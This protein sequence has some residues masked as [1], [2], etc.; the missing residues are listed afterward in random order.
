M[1]EGVHLSRLSD[2]LGKP[3]G[4]GL[5]MLKSDARSGSSLGTDLPLPLIHVAVIGGPLTRTFTTYGILLS[6]VITLITVRRS[7]NTRTSP[8][9]RIEERDGVFRISLPPERP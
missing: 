2:F 4:P 6:R 9:E 3:C 1:P 5:N 7:I 8:V